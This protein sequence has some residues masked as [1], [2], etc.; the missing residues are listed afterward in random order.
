MA[1]TMNDTRTPSEILADAVKLAE[2]TGHSYI[3]V[4]KQ[5]AERIIELLKEGEEYGEE[6]NNAVELIRKKDEK[7][8]ELQKEQQPRIL[9]YEEMKTLAQNCDA[10]YIEQS[11]E[12]SYRQCF[13]GL[14]CPGVE[15][16]KDEPYNYPGGVDFNAVDVEGDM[17]DGD[18]YQLNTPLGWRAWSG[19]PTEEQMKA[20]SWSIT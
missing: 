3:T 18:F 1:N 5:C 10:V 12:N 13:W 6:L 2:M 15:P 11:P 7:V 4:T 8:K 17:Q 16:P 20:V 14:V 9:T 19:K